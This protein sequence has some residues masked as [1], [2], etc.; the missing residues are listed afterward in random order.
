MVLPQ[1]FAAKPISQNDYDRHVDTL[2][3]AYRVPASVTD[4]CSALYPQL[5]QSMKENLARWQ[6]FN[7]P[8]IE[9]V[10]VQW[11]ALAAR[12]PTLTGNGQPVSQQDEMASRIDAYP[13]RILSS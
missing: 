13:D 5:A 10:T 6:R 4:K 7:Q 3:W 8:I 12:S 1:A 2:Y 9:E 11:Q